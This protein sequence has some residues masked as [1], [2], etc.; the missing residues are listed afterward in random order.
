MWFCIG[1]EG[2]LSYWCLST[3]WLTCF[4]CMILEMSELNDITIWDWIACFCESEFK[5]F[6]LHELHVFG[7]IC[8]GLHNWHVF[9]TCVGLH[10]LHVLLAWFC[11]ECLK[12]SV[13]IAWFFIGW[14]AYKFASLFAL[15]AFDFFC[16]L[17]I[18]S[19]HDSRMHDVNGLMFS[20]RDFVLHVWFAFWIHNGHGSILC[21]KLNC[22]H[23]YVLNIDMYCRKIMMYFFLSPDW[24][25]VFRNSAVF[26]NWLCNQFIFCVFIGLCKTF[27][28]YFKST[29]GVGTKNVFSSVLLNVLYYLHKQYERR[30]RNDVSYWFSW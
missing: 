1:M 26:W 24:K 8:F 25:C 22:K 27:R 29:R 2:M 14:L 9:D 11:M 23:W 10:G 4:A 15:H 19:L 7:L 18:K 6:G 3:A 13:M 5:D 28:M 30:V 12:W 16:Y 17:I 21:S 20:L